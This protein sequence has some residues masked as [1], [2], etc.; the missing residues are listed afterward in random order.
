[1]I[2]LTSLEEIKCIILDLPFN[3][4]STNN[5]PYLAVYLQSNINQ[6]LY[7]SESGEDYIARS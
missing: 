1:M 3:I 4:V 6:F 7:I 5:Q 2:E